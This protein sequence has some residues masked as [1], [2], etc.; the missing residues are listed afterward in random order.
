[1]LRGEFVHVRR[2]G[3]LA[4]SLLL[5][6]PSSKGTAQ[7]TLQ[8][9]SSRVNIDLL[10]GGACINLSAMNMAQVDWV[11]KKIV[12]ALHL[13]TSKP[14]RR[15]PLHRYWLSHSVL[16]LHNLPVIVRRF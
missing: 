14:S 13:G 9:G 11:L 3:S 6:D 12:R 4:C 5:S 15:R 7:Q 2:R 10:A 16:S 8:E 1:M